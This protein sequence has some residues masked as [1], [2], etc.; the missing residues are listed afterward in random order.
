M[1]EVAQFK[2]E[3]ITQMSSARRGIRT[4]EMIEVAKDEDISLDSLV[5]RIATGSIII[6]KNISTK[7]KTK[8]VGI[9]TP[10]S[11]F[12]AL[13]DIFLIH[14]KELEILQIAGL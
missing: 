13:D 9:V 8:A 6:P 4:E 2:L 10:V 1:F 14:C 7:Q 5:H 11:N 12:K 3:M